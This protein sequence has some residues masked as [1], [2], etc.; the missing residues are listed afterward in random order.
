MADHPTL[1]PASEL[2]EKNPM[3]FPNESAEYR[4]ARTALLAGRSNCGG[5]SS[6]SRHSGGSC[7]PGARSRRPIASKARRVR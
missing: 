4:T 1:T 6:A 7:R 5:T 3:H 2:A